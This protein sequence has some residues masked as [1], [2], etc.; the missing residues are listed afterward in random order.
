MISKKISSWKWE[1]I[2]VVGIIANLIIHN[3]A[4]R[5]YLNKS[6]SEA[7]TWKAFCRY[8]VAL[9]STAALLIPVYIWAQTLR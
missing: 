2:P 5:R 1:Y 4:V 9:I 6:G 8:H 3:L 7:D